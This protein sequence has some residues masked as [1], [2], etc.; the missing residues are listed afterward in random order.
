MC[1]THYTVTNH[2]CDHRTGLL[3]GGKGNKKL[4]AC[5][6]VL[7]EHRHGAS[8]PGIACPAR[9]KRT[10]KD[11][12]YPCE[13]CVEVG[14]W[15]MNLDDGSWMH[16][17]SNVVTIVEK[18]E[19]MVDRLWMVEEWDAPVQRRAEAAVVVVSTSNLLS[20]LSSLEACHQLTN[21]TSSLDHQLIPTTPTTFLLQQ[22]GR[23][24]DLARMHE[25][26]VGASRQRASFDWS[27]GKRN[28]RR[29]RGTVRMR[30]KVV[31]GCR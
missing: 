23:Q 4:V 30:V 9:R 13:G 16:T 3:G 14:R 5:D 31:T 27:R 12:P 17:P 10:V 20:A 26:D 28:S 15:R 6:R 1:I 11:V 19:D 7:N 8:K 25:Q 2:L 22:W 18:K 21:A 29:H 24:W